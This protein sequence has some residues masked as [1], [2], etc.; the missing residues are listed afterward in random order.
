MR[1]VVTMITSISERAM[2]VLLVDLTE[3]IRKR[4]FR[5]PMRNG[6]NVVKPLSMFS[7]GNINLGVK[8]DEAEQG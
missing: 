7:D 2:S 1:K 6:M 3:L 8:H 4:G 5:I